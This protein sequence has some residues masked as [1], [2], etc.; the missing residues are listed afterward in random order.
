[1]SPFL[2]SVVVRVVCSD[3]DFNALWTHIRLKRTRLFSCEYAFAN[4]PIVKKL[5]RDCR[6]CT[7]FHDQA[8]N[9]LSV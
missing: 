9:I 8:P 5:V 2:S 4:T 7:I 1:M 6:R 3:D